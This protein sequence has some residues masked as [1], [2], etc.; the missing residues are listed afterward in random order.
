MT[1]GGFNPIYFLAVGKE[2][3]G[4]QN[5]TSSEWLIHSS[6]ALGMLGFL[7]FIL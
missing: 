1:T 4:P 2:G 7:L 5:E 6:V 3:E